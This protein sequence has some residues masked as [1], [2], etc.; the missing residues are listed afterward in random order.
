MLGFLIGTVHLFQ[1][2][3]VR[4]IV[5]DFFAQVALRWAAAQHLDLNHLISMSG[6]NFAIPVLGF[7]SFESSFQCR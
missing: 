3:K 4:C 6:I 1:R 2:T 5:G 7:W